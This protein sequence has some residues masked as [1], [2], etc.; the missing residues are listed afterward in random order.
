MKIK[1]WQGYGCVNMKVLLNTPK[2]VIIEVYGN[3]EYGLERYDKY[4]ICKW[5]LNRV[6]GHKN[7][8]YMQI[9]S[10]ELEDYYIRENGMDVEHCKYT[11]TLR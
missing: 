9:S 5:L 2:K 3:H 8:N 4:D 10:L 11:I 1:H 6:N 7:D